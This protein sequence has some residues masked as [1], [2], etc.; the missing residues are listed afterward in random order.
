MTDSGM[1]APEHR[2]KQLRV[3]KEIVDKAEIL[4][5]KKGRDLVAIFQ[6]TEHDVRSSILASF[7]SAS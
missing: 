2:S 4:E 3:L 7:T 1:R 6:A 5:K